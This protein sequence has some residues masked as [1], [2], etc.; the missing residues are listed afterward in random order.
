[1]REYISLE[2]LLIDLK[3]DSLHND[4][5]DATHEAIVRLPACQPLDLRVAADE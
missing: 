3:F 5:P 4:L 2:H 1:M